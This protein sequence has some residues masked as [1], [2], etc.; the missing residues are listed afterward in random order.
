MVTGLCSTM[1]AK[2]F[3]NNFDFLIRFV[4]CRLDPISSFFHNLMFEK[5]YKSDFVKLDKKF[6]EVLAVFK[7]RKIDIKNKVILELGP[8]N[9]KINAYN[10]LLN[11]AK[12]VYLVDKF[13]RSA[14][15]SK[16]KGFD[17]QEINYI[18]K[19]FRK[20]KLFF[21]DEE[22]NPKKEFIK[23]VPKD[24]VET[25]NLKADLIFSVS[26]LEHIKNIEKNIDAMTKILNPK[27]IMFHHIDMRDHFNFENPFLFYKYSDFAWNNFL[28]KEGI[29]Y[30]NRWRYDDFIGL[31]KKKNLKI[32]WENKIT[33]PLEKERI[34]K[35][36]ADHSNL[37]IGILDIILKKQ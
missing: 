3:F 30:T 20:E 13:P 4:Y 5:L 37:D 16:Q 35:K 34:N 22:N 28:T 23:F 2:S 26:V 25:K 33:Y 17:E 15:P 1:K 32:V 8:G 11:G 19:K 12:K 7:K 9:S 29:S 36:F 27:G 31:F 10:F 21:L 24:L 6:E 14:K 18:K